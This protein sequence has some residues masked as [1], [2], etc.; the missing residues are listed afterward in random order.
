MSR[1]VVLGLAPH[2]RD[3]RRVP[4]LD[5]AQRAADELRAVDRGELGE[6]R[7]RQVSGWPKRHKL[8]QVFLRKYS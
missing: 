5:G 8:A 6:L 3:R 7:A 2:R 1:D 4:G